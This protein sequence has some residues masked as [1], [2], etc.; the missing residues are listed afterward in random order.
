M[1]GPS[2]LLLSLALYGG[3]LLPVPMLV[4]AWREWLKTRSTPPPNSWRRVSSLLTLTL[5]TMGIFLWVYTLLAE[6]RGATSQAGFHDSWIF[7]V[8]RFGSMATLLPAALGEGKLRKYLLFCAA[9]LL[10]FFCF[11]AGEAI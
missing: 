10:F 9:G 6:A 5:C 7:Y 8:G 4:L 3:L 11:T 1:E 2:L